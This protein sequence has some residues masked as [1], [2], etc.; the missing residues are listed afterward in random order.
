MAEI[1]QNLQKRVSHVLGRQTP[2]SNRESLISS[3]RFINTSQII[4]GIGRAYLGIENIRVW[5][6]EKNRFENVFEPSGSTTLERWKEPFHVELEDKYLNRGGNFG[7]LCVGYG[8]PVTCYGA[9]PTRDLRRATLGPRIIAISTNI[10]LATKNLLGKKMAAFIPELATKLES[11][12]QVDVDCGPGYNSLTPFTNIETFSLKSLKKND[13]DSDDKNDKTTWVTL[14]L[15]NL[16]REKTGILSSSVN[17][18]IIMTMT[19][20]WVS[21]HKFLPEKVC[22]TSPFS[23]GLASVLGDLTGVFNEAQEWMNG[24]ITKLT[25][26]AEILAPSAKTIEIVTIDNT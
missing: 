17:G 23:G 14:W 12:F 9:G 16:S 26:V 6:I 22:N 11:N 3:K 15:A 19:Q 20:G 21:G 25:K 13:E 8:D 5:G 4:R 18:D 7:L 10:Q 2:Q 1:A 24:Q